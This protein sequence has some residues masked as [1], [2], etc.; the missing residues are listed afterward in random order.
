MRNSG[1]AILF[2]TLILSGCAGQSTISTDT[3]AV[4]TA[5]ETFPDPVEYQ[6]GELNRESVF[7]L[8]A[9]EIAGQQR[10]FDQALGYY[11]HQARIG[12]DPAIAERATRIAQFLRDSEAVL[13]AAGI[14]AAAAPDDP[15]PLHIQANILISEQRFEEALPILEQV[16]DE[17]ST[18]AVLMIGAHSQQVP[19]DTASLYDQL[20]ARYSDKEP[21]RLDILLT[22][23]LLKRRL[24]DDSGALELLNQGLAIE[25]G[26]ADL[27]QQKVEILRQQ[28]KSAQALR[29][30][31]QALREN[32]DLKPLKVQYVQL[33]IES[34]PKAALDTMLELVDTYPDDSQLHYYFALLS[35]EH[36]QYDASRVLLNTLLAKNPKNSNLHFYLGMLDEDAGESESALA[37]YLQV[38]DGANLQSAYHRALSLL[39]QPDREQ[40]VRDII[41]QGIASHP[42]LRMELTLLLADWLNGQDKTEQALALIEEALAKNPNHVGLLYSHALMIEPLDPQRMLRDLETAVALEPD[43][44][45]L[46]NALGYSLI[47][48]SG[49]YTR[50]HLLISEALEQHP[51]DAAVLDSMGW[52][53][54]KLGRSTEALYFLR[55]AHN[56]FPDPE[57]ASHLIEVLWFSGMEDEALSLLRSSLKNAPEDERLLE[58][59]ERIGAS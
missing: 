29:L 48:Y 9:A 58:V 15:E 33:Q 10:Q 13:K 51:D 34:D 45:M 23:S 59:A 24:N 39:N 37:H 32:P 56:L 8:L 42:Q 53:L 31:R 36:R 30:V 3:T 12:H 26:Q 28:G 1:F 7:E 49:D 46:L 40:Q 4:Q 44:G 6:Q 17:G 27:L 19:P 38:N 16:L 14:W 11:L 20:L 21:E 22:R 2:G 25:P 18:E 50:A 52:V 43:N 41:E 54:Y 55:R 57:V 35:L 5:T 47:L